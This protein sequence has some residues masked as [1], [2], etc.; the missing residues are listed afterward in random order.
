MVD[1]YNRKPLR[2]LPMHMAIAPVVANPRYLNGHI[3][4]N[5]NPCIQKL[6]PTLSPTIS[7]VKY[8]L[9]WISLH[10]KMAK[11]HDSPGQRK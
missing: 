10:H 3:Y 4:S 9:Y 1:P 6:N 5:Y 2:L 7:H 8:Y 11:T